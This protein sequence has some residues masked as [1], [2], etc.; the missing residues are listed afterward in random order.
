MYKG[1]KSQ[2]P[3]KGAGREKFTLDLLSKFKEKLHCAKQK[4]SE[5]DQESKVEGDEDD[6]SW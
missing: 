4:D 5:E 2:L 3:K 6:E 1:R